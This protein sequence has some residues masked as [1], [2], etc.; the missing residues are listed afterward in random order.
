MRLRQFTTLLFIA[1]LSGCFWVS[2]PPDLT[3]ANAPA[4]LV[5]IWDQQV[6]PD[7]LE[8]KAWRTT[9]HEAL[10]QLTAALDTSSWQSSSVLPRAHGTR[11]ILRLESGRVWEIV[12]PTGR[13]P[14]FGMFDRG[15][16]GRAGSI[17]YSSAFVQTLTRMIEAQSDGPVD[18]GKE[19]WRE[20]AKGTL[21]RTRSPA[22]QT[23]ID[24][25]P[26]FPE[27]VYHAKSKSFE[28]AR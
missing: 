15:D 10:R 7:R 14:R 4:E 23:Q 3:T 21:T 16:T 18:L 11:I 27:V 20:I 25:Y 5:V 2:S 12:M 24:R 13:K 9:E 19:H 28:Y 8:R 26:G 1:T 6:A 17:A 22:A